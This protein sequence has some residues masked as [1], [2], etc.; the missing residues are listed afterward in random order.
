M[1]KRLLNSTG[2]C[3]LQKHNAFLTKTQS[4][5]AALRAAAEDNRMQ[6][7]AVAADQVCGCMRCADM[8]MIHSG[9]Q[10]VHTLT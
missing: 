5:M 6:W 3:M 9:F 2:V 10:M 7:D 1:L 4:M 8:L